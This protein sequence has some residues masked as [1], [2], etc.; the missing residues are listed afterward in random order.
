MWRCRTCHSSLLYHVFPA[1]IPL[2]LGTGEEVSRGTVF[3]SVCE[4]SLWW[5]AGMTQ[6]LKEILFM[7]LTGTI[8]NPQTSPAWK[9]KLDFIYLFNSFL[10]PI[11]N[12][13]SQFFLSSNHVIQ[14]TKILFSHKP[15]TSSSSYC[16][17]F[18]ESK[19]RI[20]HL[21]QLHL[22]LFI[23]PYWYF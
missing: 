6:W 21:S 13:V 17:K 4:A 22:I 8:S 23:W 10:L 11:K 5:W 9:Y 2:L 1:V 18:F 7:T 16:S 14:L 20:L 12:C 3:G 19:C 15:L